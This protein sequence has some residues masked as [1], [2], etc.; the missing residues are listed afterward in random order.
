M[1]RVCVEKNHINPL[2]GVAIRLKHVRRV[3]GKWS[4]EE[5][6]DI[7]QEVRK[8]EDDTLRAEL[9]FVDDESTEN[10]IALHKAQAML[11]QRIATEEAF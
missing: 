10:R 7:F 3:L 5:Y 9:L 11:K 8:A 2:T 1:S 4:R 6:G